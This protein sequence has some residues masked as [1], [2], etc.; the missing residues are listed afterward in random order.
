MIAGTARSGTTWLAEAVASQVAGRIV[1]EP[2]YVGML[3]ASNATMVLNGQYYYQYLRPGDEAPLLHE[4]CRLIMSGRIRDPWTDKLVNRLLPRCRVIKVIRANLF[5]RW[6][7]DRFPE[8]PILFVLR[9]PCAVVHSRLRSEYA[10]DADIQPF[11]DQNDLI[12]DFLSDKLDVVRAARTPAE[13]HAVIWSVSNMV[14]LSQFHG[15]S[16]PIVH[17][18]HLLTRPQEEVPRIFSLL[19]RDFG[20]RVYGQLKVPSR[21]TKRFSAAI[22]GADPLTAW[23]EALSPG[24][25][26]AILSIVEAFGLDSYYDDTPLPLCSSEPSGAAE[27]AVRT[28]LTGSPV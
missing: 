21:T 3:K 10:T 13:K 28:R 24:D 27:R 9:H 16:L 23:R 5:L 14:P 18:E 17:Y 20:D 19:Q 26:A 15:K 12:E 22:S 2:F 8:V 4:Y 7:H 1:F 6:F 11:L 25:V